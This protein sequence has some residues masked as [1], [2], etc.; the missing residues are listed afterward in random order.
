MQLR[1]YLDVALGAIA[2]ELIRQC[3]DDRFR[4]QRRRGSTGRTRRARGRKQAHRNTLHSKP[5]TVGHA[6]LRQLQCAAIFPGHCAGCKQH[7]YNYF[8]A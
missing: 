1:E 3:C 7:C 2:I 5:T 4:Q 8:I 6:R